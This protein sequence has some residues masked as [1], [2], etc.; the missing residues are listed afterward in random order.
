MTYETVINLDK[1]WILTIIAV[2]KDEI[3]LE[4]YSS[5]KDYSN[6]ENAVVE[7]FLYNDTVKEIMAALFANMELSPQ[8]Y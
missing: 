6:N 5:K 1:G 7:L 3:C 8:D 2:D 4:L